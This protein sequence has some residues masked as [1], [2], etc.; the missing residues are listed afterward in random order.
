MTCGSL[1]VN[2]TASHRKVQVLPLLEENGGG[3]D[4]EGGEHNVV[5]R[6]HDACVEQVKSLIQIVHLQR[7]AN[8]HQDQERPC[9]PVTELVFFSCK[10]VV[11]L[12]TPILHNR[13]IKFF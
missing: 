1:K 6:S 7:D 3:N 10:K 2:E 4:D 9:Q 12:N 13:L 11:V 8:N 5:H